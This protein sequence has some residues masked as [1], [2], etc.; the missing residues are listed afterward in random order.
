MTS[1]ESAAEVE[2]VYKE[3]GAEWEKEKLWWQEGWDEVSR[4]RKACEIF[5]APGTPA[6]SRASASFMA[7]KCSHYQPNIR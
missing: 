7:C 4:R 1:A 3:A 5:T 6:C 2:K